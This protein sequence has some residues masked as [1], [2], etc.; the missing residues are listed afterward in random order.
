VLVRAF[1]SVHETIPSAKLIIAGGGPLRGQMEDLALSLGVQDG[2]QFLGP[3]KRAQVAKL[4]RHC[5][6]FVLPS[7]FE[8]FGIAIL[9]AMACKK[10]VVATTVGGI[11]EIIENGK[12]GILVE[13]DNPAALAEAL[14]TVLRDPALQRALASHGYA[15][16]HERFRSEKTGSTYEMVFAELL[17]NAS[18]LQGWQ[19]AG[20]PHLSTSSENALRSSKGRTEAVK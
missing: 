8:T 11:P 5:T 17:S 16:V 19:P 2:I 7:R 20:K 4:L 12:N 15:T 10:P 18:K 14:V 6:A 1:K 9:E 3:I 13:P